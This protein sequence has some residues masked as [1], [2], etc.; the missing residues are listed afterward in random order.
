MLDLTV[1]ISHTYIGGCQAE[2]ISTSIK[3]IFEKFTK[4]IPT[5]HAVKLHCGDDTMVG[6]SHL[7]PFITSVMQGV[8]TLSRELSD[9]SLRY[10]IPKFG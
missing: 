7:N 2:E 1:G 9:G 6:N 5:R 8:V 3:Y 10:V 4:V